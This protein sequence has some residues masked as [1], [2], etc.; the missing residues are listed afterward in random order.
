[1]INKVFLLFCISLVYCAT[2]IP[3]TSMYISTFGKVIKSQIVEKVEEVPVKRVT[4]NKDNVSSTIDT[5]KPFRRFRLIIYYEYKCNLTNKKYT[6]IHKFGEYPQYLTEL[7]LVNIK[8]KYFKGSTIEI[9]VNKANRSVSTLISPTNYP[10]VILAS[11][12]VSLLLIHL[13]IVLLKIRKNQNIPF[14]PAPIFTFN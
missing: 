12:G 2:L 8:R 5:K 11:V 14:R 6:G 9:F 13:L 4:I 3:K 7:E 10:R 1:M